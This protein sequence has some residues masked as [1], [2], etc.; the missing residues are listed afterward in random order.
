M[1]VWTAGLG[2]VQTKDVTKYAI[3][4]HTEYI[5]CNFFCILHTSRPTERKE[6]QAKFLG[7]T[8]LRDKLTVRVRRLSHWYG[9]FAELPRFKLKDAWSLDTVDVAHMV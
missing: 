8:C 2:V 6:L 1:V 3:Y 9:A 4:V 7:A 5:L